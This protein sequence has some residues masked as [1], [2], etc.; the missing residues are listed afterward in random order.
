MLTLSVM[1]SLQIPKY[2]LYSNIYCIKT[3]MHLILPLLQFGLGHRR[4]RSRCWL[5]MLSELL[6]DALYAILPYS[7]IAP[8]A[9]DARDLGAC[10]PLPLAPFRAGLHPNSISDLRSS[11]RPKIQGSTA[12][13]LSRSSTLSLTLS[14]S[15]PPR[16]KS[17]K[18]SLV[19]EA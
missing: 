17:A 19:M 16:P 7:G 14:I 6:V 5:A 9:N 3:Q 15:L 12:L 18:S 8:V 10:A 4:P 1:C 2:S 11:N 13:L